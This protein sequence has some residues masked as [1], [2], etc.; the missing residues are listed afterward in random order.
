VSF[1]LTIEERPGYLYARVRGPNSPETVLEYLSQVRAACERARCRSVLIDEDLSGAGLQTF[2]IFEMVS[3]Q[4]AEAAKTFERIAFV[5]TNPDHE[6]RLM[7]FAETVAVNRGLNLRVFSD[8]AEAE[9]W[10]EGP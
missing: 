5:D 3:R 4:S 7:K 9:R 10:M 1:E 8:L 2:D 6:G